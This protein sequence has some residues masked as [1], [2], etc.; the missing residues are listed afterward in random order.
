M[1]FL[2]IFFALWF[3][4]LFVTHC[5]GKTHDRITQGC[6]YLLAA[7]YFLILLKQ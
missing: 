1:K 5:Y 6:A 7:V 3:L 2:D 4:G